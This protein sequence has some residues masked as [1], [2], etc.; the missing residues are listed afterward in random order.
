MSD[1][2][3]LR[4]LN[5][6]L[7]ELVRLQLAGEIDA[8][9]AWRARRDMLAATEESW[10][11]LRAAEQPA[12]TKEKPVPVVKPPLAKRVNQQVSN[13]AAGIG[14]WLLRRSWRLPAWGLLLLLA[15]GTFIYV[16]SL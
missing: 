16:G 1:A 3:H 8:D 14:P 5:L 15:V 9:T 6:A 2:D 11:V 10:E 12:V 7:R 13:A 4:D